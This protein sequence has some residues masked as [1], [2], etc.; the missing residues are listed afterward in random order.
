[1]VIQESLIR[2]NI[3]IVVLHLLQERDMYGYEIIQQLNIRS[4]GEFT[5]KFGS[6]YPVMYRM[7]ERGI[8]TEETVLVG[9]RR[10]RK[11]YHL[12]DIGT[13]YLETIKSEYFRIASGMNKILNY[14][15]GESECGSPK[16]KESS[17]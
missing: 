4:D 12:T 7:I 5:V 11:Y 16:K 9:K 10:I 6:L 13:E 2:G 15:G 3:D 17:I 1:M 14:K 8:L